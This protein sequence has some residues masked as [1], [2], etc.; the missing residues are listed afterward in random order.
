LNHRLGGEGAAGDGEDEDGHQAA[1]AKAQ[2]SQAPCLDR[3]KV[4]GNQPEADDRLDDR[5]RPHENKRK[6]SDSG[7]AH[8]RRMRRDQ[9]LRSEEAN[10]CPQ[11][12][13]DCDGVP[14]GRQ[15]DQRAAEAKQRIA[16]AHKDE[17]ADLWEKRRRIA[18]W[19]AAEQRDQREQNYGQREEAQRVV[20]APCPG[21]RG[22]QAEHHEGDGA[23]VLH[24]RQELFQGR[25]MP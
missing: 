18:G 13:D 17:Q 16:G 22:D 21:N 12:C 5:C 19:D 4:T 2:G 25:P 9:S 3:G 8:R 15:R 7:E 10:A 11:H 14:P 1:E 24:V 23:R 20:T 6:Y